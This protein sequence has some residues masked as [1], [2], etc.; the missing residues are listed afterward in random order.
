MNYAA[1]DFGSNALRLAIAP[2]PETAGSLP[3]VIHFER[4]VHD[5]GRDVFRDGAGSLATIDQLCAIFAHLRQIL[6]THGVVPENVIARGTSALRDARNRDQIIAAIQSASG[7]Q[8]RLLAGGEE[9]RLT[10]WA[11]QASLPAIADMLALDIGGG[12]TEFVEIR[13]RTVCQSFSMN[14]GSTRLLQAADPAAL[15]DEATVPVP[16]MPAHAVVA[17]TGGSAA[18]LLGVAD[19]LGLCRADERR[20]SLD[21]ARAVLAALQP[22]SPD[23][24]IARYGVEASRRETIVPAAEI[25]IR[26]AERA[27]I[28]AIEIPRVGLVYGLL[29]EIM[30]S[31]R[32]L[33]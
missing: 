1:I 11:I 20:M 18:A 15:L 24:R 7:I 22:L 16:A 2:P 4:L 13:D 26:V 9:A 30:Q 31:T 19:Q 10:G 33:D 21:A 14:V 29:L 32:N 5:L 6:H 3:Q 28:T 25:L 17:A 27:G 8:L 23:E 12:S